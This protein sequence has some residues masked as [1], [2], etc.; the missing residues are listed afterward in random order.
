M[1]LAGTSADDGKTIELAGAFEAAPGVKQAFRIVNREIDA[2]HFVIEM[3]AKLPDGSEGAS[4]E[5][6]YSR[7]R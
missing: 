1:S 2:D 3:H 5:T 4:F 7:S 6:T